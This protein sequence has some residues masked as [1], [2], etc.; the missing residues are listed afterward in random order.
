M[1]PN[2]KSCSGFK[3]MEYFGYLRKIFVESLVQR[4]KRERGFGYFLQPLVKHTKCCKLAFA[5]DNA[6]SEFCRT[7]KSIIFW[8]LQPLPHDSLK[9]RL[10][11]IYSS[12]FL[13]FKAILH[14]HL[15]PTLLYTL[16]FLFLLKLQSCSYQNILNST[17]Q[18]VAGTY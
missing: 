7:Q 3:D 14:D 11:G 10:R 9:S 17:S 5:P 2:W 8:Y 4:L 18:N 12:F 15:T 6:L 1:C 13:S 16:E